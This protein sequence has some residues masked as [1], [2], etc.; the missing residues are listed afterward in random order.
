MVLEIKIECTAKEAAAYKNILS[1][2][3]DCTW[4]CLALN[5]K[6]VITVV[7]HDPMFFYKFGHK[8][9]EKILKVKTQ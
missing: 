8:V 1:K 6:Y 3:K 7:H 5:G 2:E 4:S 9:A